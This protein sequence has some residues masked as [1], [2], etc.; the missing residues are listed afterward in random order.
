MEKNSEV[1]VEIFNQLIDSQESPLYSLDKESLD[2]KLAEI[3]NETIKIYLEQ[4]QSIT[5]LTLGK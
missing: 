3:L 1:F 4:K 2:K 5:E